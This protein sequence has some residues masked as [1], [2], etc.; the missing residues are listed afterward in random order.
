MSKS[1]Q[2]IFLDAAHTHLVKWKIFDVCASEASGYPL[3]Q[4]LEMRTAAEYTTAPAIE[5][6]GVRLLIM[7]VAYAFE[8]L[9]V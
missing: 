4:S 2:C 9:V 8:R 3:Y 6:A 7:L 1:I 5:E